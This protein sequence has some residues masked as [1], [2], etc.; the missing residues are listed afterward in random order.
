MQT[1]T[2][3]VVY[4]YIRRNSPNSEARLENSHLEADRPGTKAEEIEL[5]I[6]VEA[7]FTFTKK[8]DFCKL[9]FQGSQFSERKYSQ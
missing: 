4:S 9:S 5:R 2:V 8:R 3:L 7:L 1:E 6:T